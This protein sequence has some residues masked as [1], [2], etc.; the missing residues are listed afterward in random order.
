[1][2]VLAVEVDEPLK[3]QGA[4]LVKELADRMLATREHAAS[5]G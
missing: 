2:T 3:A 1:M 4:K 5:S